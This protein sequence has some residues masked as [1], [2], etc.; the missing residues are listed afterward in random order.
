MQRETKNHCPICRI[1]LQEEYE[2]VPR[3]WTWVNC[4][5]CGQHVFSEPAFDFLNRLA[6]RERPRLATAVFSVGSNDP[7]GPDELHGLLQAT[8]L[9]EAS[10]RIDRFLNYMTQ[11]APPGGRVML[12]GTRLSARLGCEDAGAANWVIRQAHTLGYLTTAENG[13]DKQLT[14]QG[15][16]RHSDLM[17]SGQGSRHAFMAMAYSDQTL[18]S[19]LSDHLRPAVAQTGFELRTLAGDHQTA[20]SIDNRMRVEIRTSRFMVC[21]LTHGNNGA[22]WEAGFAEGLGRPVFYICR[23]DVLS[24]PVH[25]NRPHF[26]INHQLIVKWRP[27]NPAKGMQEL[28]DVIRATLPAEAKMTDD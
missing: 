12:S 15:W 5:N 3:G 13:I 23:E 14:I 4:E 16:Q 8:H 21:D 27:D 17:K 24:D 25:S 19:L 2:V 22:Y 28:K 7:L 11:A 1:T 26:D 20:G 10:E 9:P 6:P 18:W